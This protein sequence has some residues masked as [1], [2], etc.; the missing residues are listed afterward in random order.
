VGTHSPAALALTGGIGSDTFV[1]RALTDRGTSGDVI[2]DFTKGQG[3]DVLNLREVL[4]T[5][6]GYN[7]PNAFSGGYLRFT[8]DRTD[9][10]V[11]VD[12]DGGAN[13]FVTLVTLTNTLLTQ[14]DAA[15]YLL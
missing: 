4:S 8:A 6:S 10:L 11:Q 15:N 3:G 1:Y 13:G 2:T 5:F 9:T 14:A 7:G 12:S